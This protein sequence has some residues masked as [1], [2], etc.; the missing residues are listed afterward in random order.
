MRAGTVLVAFILAFGGLA[1]GGELVQTDWSAGVD[2]SGPQ[3]WWGAGFASAEQVSWR[4]IP[5]QL[6]L[7]ST[8]VSEPAKHVVSQPNYGAYGLYVVDMDA[9]GDMDVVG[10]TDYTKDVIIWFNQGGDPVSW[11]EQV[12]DNG[13][14]G[15]TSVHP[16]DLDGDGDMDIVAAAENPGDNVSW[17][18]NDGG[19]PI[20]WTRL[21]IDDDVPVACNVFAA[22]VDGDGRVDVLS[23]SWSDRFVAWWQND[24]GDPPQWTRHT[25]DGSF[26]GAHSAVAGDVDGD[27]DTDVVAT[28]AQSV[29]YTHLRAH[30]T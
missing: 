23:T 18:R 26:V 17:W 16:V 1:S 30:E 22:D 3:A 27:G 28:A 11:S 21:L 10:T 8:A 24:G 25:L 2:A 20:V 5:G 6:A 15:G 13:Y 9:D 12:V 19:E 14:D 4:S 29:S 7:S